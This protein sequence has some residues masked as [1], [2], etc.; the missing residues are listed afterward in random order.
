[1]KYL[2]IIVC[3]SMLSACKKELVGGAACYLGKQAYV[4]NQGGTKFA[5]PNAFTPNGDGRN[6]YFRPIASTNLTSFS[7]TIMDN[8][9]N[10]VFRTIDRY[11]QG[12]DG[13]NSGYMLASGKYGVNFQFVTTNGDRVNQNYCIALLS[14]N[15]SNCIPRD[16]GDQYFFENQ[17]DPVT[18]QPIY[19]S[20]EIICN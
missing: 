5:L 8:D 10:V 20:G 13:R 14:Y 7:M 17:Y 15:T 16:L 19:G 1:M 18:L 9:G 12:W 6:D 11:T 2:I 3:F 4:F